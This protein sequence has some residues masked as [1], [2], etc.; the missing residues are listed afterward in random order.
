MGAW[1]QTDGD[2]GM[3][4]DIPIIHVFLA[5]TECFD[6]SPLLPHQQNK[7]AIAAKSISMQILPQTLKKYMYFD[8]FFLSGIS[9]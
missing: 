7:N 1:P 2:G 5:Q 6:L 9:L 8:T 4:P 3:A